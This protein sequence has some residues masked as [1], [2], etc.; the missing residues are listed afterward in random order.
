MKKFIILVIFIVAIVL[1]YNFVYDKMQKQILADEN[2][3]NNTVVQDS[4]KNEVENIIIDDTNSI[5][6]T[7]I[8]KE[9]EKESIV[10][11]KTTGTAVYE[12]KSDVGSTDKKEEAINLVKQ[13][14]GED[15]TVTFRCDHVSN[16]GEYVIAVISKDSAKVKNY[17]RVNLEN[18][19]VIVDY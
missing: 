1:T 8:P 4:K 3:V 16:N 14:W 12:E 10:D 5:E 19:S 7:K 9:T 18:K 15:D 6:K 17:F 2:V 11:E 13:K